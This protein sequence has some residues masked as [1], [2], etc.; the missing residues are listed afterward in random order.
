MCSF[1]AN[2]L[3]NFM[4]TAS[5]IL[6]NGFKPIILTIVFHIITIS[7]LPNYIVCILMICKIMKKKRYLSAYT[8]CI[9]RISKSRKPSNNTSTSLKYNY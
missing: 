7:I 6:F 3:T 9:V 8:I 1:Y 2:C 5:T 4:K